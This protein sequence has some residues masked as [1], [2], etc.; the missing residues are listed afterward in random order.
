MAK[1]KTK[2]ELKAEELKAKRVWLEIE[3]LTFFLKENHKALVNAVK[4]NMY[5]K[6]KDIT[7][8]ILALENLLY[9]I[10]MGKK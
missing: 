1:E 4:R 7:I 6:D 9:K 10:K 8:F 2:S 5:N 3:E